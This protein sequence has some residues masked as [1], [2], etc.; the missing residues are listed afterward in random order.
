VRS[1][2]G[3]APFAPVAQISAYGGLSCSRRADAVWCWGSNQAGGLGNGTTV[4][5]TA[6]IASLMQRD[7]ID[8]VAGNAHACARTRDASLWCWGWNGFGQLG[9]GT[10]TDRPTPVQ[11]LSGARSVAAGIYHTC[12]VRQDATVWCWGQNQFGQLGD[13]T[14][15]DRPAPVL[16]LAG[17][18]RVDVGEHFTCARKLDGTLWCWGENALGQLG[19]GAASPSPSLA[20]AAVALGGR[21]AAFSL[22]AFFGCALLAD[23]QLAC[24]GS[25]DNGQLGDG[26]PALGGRAT[27]VRVQLSCP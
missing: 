4:D 24:W 25:D 13:G 3:A 15:T 12:A 6:P 9:D 11:V 5:S 14:T 22:G 26:A 10:T 16:A 17:A 27:P 2:G 7:V 19:N 1:A 8:V 21:V 20:P 18:D 23:G